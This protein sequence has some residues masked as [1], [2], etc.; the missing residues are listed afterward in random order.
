[1]RGG[2]AVDGEKLLAASK[3]ARATLLT[4]L[5]ERD[6]RIEESI[7]DLR[8]VRRL[9]G[10]SAGKSTEYIVGGAIL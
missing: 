10:K 2:P 8:A 6:N 1:M 5:V 7:F 9:Q 3:L 4:P